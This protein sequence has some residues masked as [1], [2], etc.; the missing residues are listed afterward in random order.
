MKTKGTQLCRLKRMMP[1]R[2]NLAMNLD[3]VARRRVSF[4]QIVVAIETDGL[5]DV[6]AHPNAG[7]YPNQRLLVVALDG[8]AYLVPYVEETDYFFLKTIIPSRKASR[9]YLPKG[10][11]NDAS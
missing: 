4:E 6:L 1:F 2:W 10:D 3:L 9:D 8:Y 5:L 7:R 11:P